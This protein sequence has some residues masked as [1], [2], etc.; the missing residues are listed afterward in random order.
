MHTKKYGNRTCYYICDQMLLHLW[1]VITFVP[2]TSVT[3]TRKKNRISKSHFSLWQPYRDAR[4]SFIAVNIWYLYLFHN[5]SMRRFVI[6]LTCLVNVVVVKRQT[7]FS[8]NGACTQL[9]TLQGTF[10]GVLYC[11][12]V[13]VNSSADNL[14]RNVRDVTQGVDKICWSNSKKKKESNASTQ[15]MFYHL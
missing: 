5:I 8:F 14:F 12:H 15:L 7:L 3:F 4:R 10:N 9:H 1:P 6:Q 13:R 2:S 11:N